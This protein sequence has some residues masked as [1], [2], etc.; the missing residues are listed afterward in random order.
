MLN[1]IQNKNQWLRNTLFDANSQHL[2]GTSNIADWQNVGGVKSPN[3]GQKPLTEEVKSD[4]TKA[5]PI[6]TEAVSTQNQPATK[7]ADGNVLHLE[8]N[9]FKEGNCACLA[10]LGMMA[11]DYNLREKLLEPSIVKQE[12]GSFRVY[13][14]GGEKELNG[15][16]I[17]N[18]TGKDEKGFYVTVK[19]AD[20]RE[21][22][23]LVTEASDRDYLVLATAAQKY[24]ELY[25]IRGDSNTR[26]GMYPEGLIA[27]FTGKD[28]VKTNASDTSALDSY[29]QNPQL[30]TIVFGGDNIPKRK[31]GKDSDQVIMGRHAYSLVP[32][33]DGQFKVINPW[34]TKNP[35]ILT[36]K[37]LREYMAHDAYID[38]F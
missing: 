21:Y 27:L 20:L 1:G 12:D 3:D 31:I 28:T 30:G 14:A 25:G 6:L 38:S 37:Q 17:K 2:K 11:Q 29:F 23:D 34:D 32:L 22:K 5:T 19:E 10:V 36:E 33:A 35:M 26:D 4:E 16:E 24:A 8:L 15:Q 18:G 13:L 7:A 9:Q